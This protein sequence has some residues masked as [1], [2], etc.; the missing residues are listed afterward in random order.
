MLGASAGKA[1]GLRRTWKLCEGWMRL[2]GHVDLVFEALLADAH[3]PPQQGARATVLASLKAWIEETRRSLRQA[4][5]RAELRPNVDVRAVALELH[6]LVWGRGWT[7]ALCG[8]GAA[9]DGILRAVWHRLS[10]VAADPT[11]TLPLESE[12][13]APIAAAEEEDE[14]VDVGTNLPLD[15]WRMAL[16]PSDPLYQAFLRHEIM[17]DPRAFT[18]QAAVTEQDKEAAERFRKKEAQARSNLQT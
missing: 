2:P 10:A 15:T 8:P 17:G 16:E 13:A 7:A 6:Q 12:I 5:L 18:S 1:L 14:R 3:S 4:Q 9:A 11:A